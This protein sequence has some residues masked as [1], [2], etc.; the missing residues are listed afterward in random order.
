MGGG[1]TSARN[2]AEGR[3]L[4]VAFVSHCLTPGEARAGRIGGAER[5]AAE[6][7]AA[8][9][10][11]PDLEVT[12]LIA[13]AASDRLGFV[14]FA[15][16]ALSGLRRLARAGAIDAV[17]FTAL[18]TA[19]MSLVLRRIFDQTG[20]VTASICHGHDVTWG[21]PPYQALAPHVLSALDA[22]SP[23]SAATGS[24]CLARGLEP[25]RMHVV[26]NGADMSRFSPA[27]RFEDRRA[28][29]SAGFPEAAASL[30][31]QDLVLCT[32][33][34]Q[35]RRKGHAWF[36][37]EVMPRLGPD[38]TLWLAGDGPEAPVI[39]AAARQAGVAARVLRL[40]AVSETQLQ[41]L[42]RGADLFVMPNVPVA[43]DIE[44]FG[45]VMLEANLGGMPVMAAD[46]E[47]LAE[48]VTEG[49]NGRL[50]PTLD[51]AAFARVIA[52]LNADPDQRARL[53]RDGEAHVRAR[54]GWAPVADRQVEILRRL[55]SERSRRPASRQL[56][57][58]FAPR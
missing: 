26:P 54:F 44:G 38:V 36:V 41:A 5:A 21:F 18:P 43:G 20:V 32:V 10:A 33:G 9:R 12:P 35:V 27:P 47:G 23:V 42:Y 56:T 52:E 17:L 34:R 3:R 1:L 19:W 13:S 46:F 14:S 8:L 53:G 48:V 45:L 55:R 24:H 57:P 39:D 30:A 49:V 37:R 29:L 15:L 2:A 28:I 58:A 11:R 51:A 4:R 25:S 40:G 7:L 16:G 50:A 6:L 31:P 22:V